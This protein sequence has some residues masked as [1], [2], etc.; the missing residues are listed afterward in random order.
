MAPLPSNSTGVLFV[1]YETCLSPH[2]FQLRVQDGA[3]PSDAMPVMA[4]FLAAFDTTI[5]E[6]SILGAR[7]REAGADITLPLTWTG[8]SGYGTSEGNVGQTAWFYDFIGRSM[9]GRRC[10]LTVFG[11]TSIQDGTDDN[12]RIAA[13]GA[14][15]DALNVLK[16]ADS[17]ICAIDG[18]QIVWYDYINM[19]V[20]AY[21]RNKIR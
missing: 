15:L 1:D 10:R 8:D 12:Y 16:G 21:W 3:E 18:A 20:N 6:M 2:T 9:L 7:G 17:I 19:G 13:T 11:A 14:L 5:K 4:D